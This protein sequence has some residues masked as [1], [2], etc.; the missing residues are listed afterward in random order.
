MRL[1][2]NGNSIQAFKVLKS[3][4][5]SP[6]LADSWIDISITPPEKMKAVNTLQKNNI[7]IRDF[8]IEDIP[9]EEVISDLY[10]KEK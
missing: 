2:T 8:Y 3:S 4:G 10:E 7:F 9:L 1:F 6:V 5:F